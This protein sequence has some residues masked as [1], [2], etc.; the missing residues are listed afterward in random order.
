MLAV[1]NHALF[2]LLDAPARPD[3]FT[4]ALAGALATWLVYA[5]MALL[6]GLWVWGRQ[7]HRGALLATALGIGVALGLNQLAGLLWFEPRPFMIGIGHTL[8]AHA[9]DNSFPSDHAA[10]MWGLGFGLVATGASRRWGWLFCLLGLAVAWAR[11]YLGVHFPIDMAGSLATG[12]LGG[13]A[14][15]AATPA[16]ARWLLP[17]VESSY[18]LA[19]R[20]LHLPVGVFPRREKRRAGT[21][22]ARAIPPS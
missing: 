11:I 19:L 7:A 21:P 1:P 10:F 14:A 6:V 3:P 5:G 20:T 9:A 17:P 8:M 15:R 13:G 4:V 22:R 18:E 2:L 16:V 12:S